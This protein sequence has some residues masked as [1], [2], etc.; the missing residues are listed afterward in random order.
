MIHGR[1]G[2]QGEGIEVFLH[3]LQVAAAVEHVV[4]AG[5]RLQQSW[6]LLVVE[7]GFRAQTRP[8]VPENRL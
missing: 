6:Q 1:V 5:A 3:G 4:V 8:I 2:F 7:Q